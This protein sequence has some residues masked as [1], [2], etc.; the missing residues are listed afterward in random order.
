M[1]TRRTALLANATRI[2]L[3]LISVGLLAALL[4]SVFLSRGTIEDAEAAAET[5]AIDWANTVLFDAIAPDEIQDPV[6]G[7]DYRELLIIVQAGIR[8][9]DRTARVR[10]WNAEGELVFSDDQRDKIGEYVATDNPQ[11]QS[12]LD[13]ETVSVATQA[14]VAPKSG[15]A[16]SDEK[17]FQTFVPL[18]LENQVGISGV[19]QIDQR[20]AAIEAEASDVW[21]TVRL[22]LVLALT[23]VVGLFLFSLRG[24][25]APVAAPRAIAG[26]EPVTDDAAPSRQ[27]RR[28]LHRAAKA[29]DRLRAM[30]ERATKAEAAAKAAEATATA[31]A[32]DATKAEAAMIEAEGTASAA[33][34]RLGE[35]E[36]RAARAEEHAALAEERATVAEAAMREA[37]AVTGGEAPRRG[38]PAMGAVAV[39]AVAG[40]LESRL[41]A[42]ESE[43]E[44]L[45]GEVGRLRSALA[46]REAEFAIAHEGASTG[47]TEVDDVR[48]L[49]A[50]AEQRA[51]EAEQ[52][53]AELEGRLRTAEGELAAVATTTKTNKKS[54]EERQAEREAADELRAAQLQ[55]NDLQMKLTEAEAALETARAE[56]AKANAELTMTREALAGNEQ[57]ASSAKG[58]VERAAAVE[59]TLAEMETLVRDVEARAARSDAK[60]TETQAELAKAQSA[61][62][63][64]ESVR[65]ELAAE[66]EHARTEAVKAPVPAGA[67]AE[68]VEA[69][70]TRIA[71]LEEARR[72][73]VVE[74]QRAQEALANTQFETTQA[75]RRAK[76]LEVELRDLRGEPRAPA[77]D[78]APEAAPEPAEE[79]TSF[80]A[81]LAHLVAEHEAPKEPAEP[82]APAAAPEVPVAASEEG[83]SLRE[84]LARAAAARHRMAG[85]PPEPDR[86]RPDRQ[87]PDR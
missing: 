63:E 34:A 77:A 49:A 11:I 86:Q 18:R 6:L 48:H 32:V 33:A 59:A 56:L 79:P 26:A 36:E 31:T 19:V 46:E 70:R 16:G 12:A 82:D 14:T 21:R 76:E 30:T 27:D 80:A 13:G 20:Y 5:R 23:V 35:L 84:R 85:T 71:E 25:P 78:A 53:I 69:L 45:A 9:D 74:L 50:E 58:V 51:A 65:A 60:A 28:A 83:L 17:L 3:G 61:L 66:L 67:L 15:L 72:S 7:A 87:R 62:A 75:R 81:R 54:K 52:R 8:S 37:Q 40:E 10:V 2:G 55:A 39:S 57:A 42:V 64:A 38:V 43:R 41:R 68:D 44:R 47:V 24:R 1:S 4:L 73:D 22:A 29:E